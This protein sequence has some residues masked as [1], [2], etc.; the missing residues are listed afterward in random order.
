MAGDK[1]TKKKAKNTAKQ[2]FVS[3]WPSTNP[4]SSSRAIPPKTNEKLQK[5]VSP[6]LD[7]FNYFLTEG[8]DLAVSDI[9]RVPVE[10]PNQQR[11][12]IWIENAQLGFPTT[13]NQITGEQKLLPSECRQRGVSY[14]A[15]LVVTLA[16]SFGGSQNVE[17]VQKV[18]GE[19]PIMVRS[20]HCHLNGMS[21]SELVK[22]KEE[23]NEMG[24]YF[25]CNGNERCVR[26]LQMPRRHHIMAVRRGAFANRGDLYTELAVFMKCVKRDQAA[27][28]V[29]VHYLQDGNATVRFGVKKQ[30]FMIP[31]GLVLKALY[32][33]TDREIY[34]RVLRG[35]HENTYLSARVEL[36]LREAKKFS[37]YSRDEALSYLGKHFRYAMPYV[38]ESMSNVEIGSK[39]LDD[40]LFVHIP[41]GEKG[42]TQKVELLCLMLRKLYAFAKGDVPEDNADSVMNHELL[43]PGHLYLMILKEKLQEMLQSMRANILKETS[44]R[45]KTVVMDQVFLRKMW[46]RTPNVGHAMT[47][48]LN[49]GNLRSSSGL[50]LLQVA[51]YTIVAEKLNYYR[52]FSHFRS[53][54]RGQ[55]F[56][57]MKTTAVRKLLPD[58]WGFLCPVHTP[59][60]SPCGLLNHLAVE[61]QLVSYPAYKADDYLQQEVRLSRFLASLGMI[62]TSGYADGALIV[63]YSYLPVMMNG[64]VLGGAPAEVCKRIADVLR[65]VKSAESPKERD[66]NGIVVNLEVCLILPTLGGPFPGLFLSA[67]AARMSRP[68]MQMDTKRI[69]YIGPMEQVFMDIA[70]TKADIR[71]ATTHMEIKPTNML[72][73]VASLTPFSDYNQSP[74]NMY[75]CQMAKQT[76]GTPA[77]SI[78]NRTDNK[79][80]RIQSPQIPIVQNE[81]LREYQLDEYPL[82]TNAVVAVISY[83]GFD[84]EDAMILNKA[85]YERGFGHASVY[86][87]LNVD[88][89]AGGKQ[90]SAQSKKYFS[91]I[92][93]DGSGEFCSTKLDHD[94]FPH[95]GQ[96]V[97]KGDPIAGWIDETTGEAS[98]QKHKESEPAIIE[99]INMIGGSSQASE[100]TKASIKLRFCR[101]PTIG[102]KFSSR[103]GQKGV[104]SIQ[105]PQENMPFSE[106]GM[107]PDIIINPHAFPSR[108][109]IGMLIESMAAKTG[110][111]K[112][113]YMDATPFKF[114]EKDRVIDYFG[115]QLKEHGYNYMG[116]EPLYSGISGTVMQADIYIGV[117]Y[118]Q[119][120][121]HMVSD[122]SQVRATGPT[123]SLT[124]QPVKGRKKGGGIRLGEMERDSLLA[125][126]CAFLLQDRLMNCSD[127]HIATVCT[128]CGSLLSNATQRSTVETAGQGD[129]AIAMKSKTQWYC[130]VC[131][132]G[133]GCHAVAMPYVFRYLANEKLLAS[134]NLSALAFGGGNGGGGGGDNE[135][136]APGAYG[137]HVFS[138][139]H[140]Y[141]QQCTQ[142]TVYENTA[143]AVVESSLE[144][145]NATIFAYGQTGTGKTYTME[146]FNSGSGSV[147]ERGIIPRAIEQIFCHIQANVSARC[148]FL[149]RASYL[150]IYNESISDLLKPERA[151][152]TIR[153][154]RRR[155][156][157]VE[158]LSE[159]V[160]RSPEEIYG[161][162][163]RGGAM[164]ATGSTKMNE[165]SSRS[166]AVFIII[167]EQSKT[168]YVDSK[169]ND[170]A[171]EEFMALVNAYQARHGGAN[172][173]GNAKEGGGG[174]GTNANGTV[175]LHPKLEAMV[176]Q[177]FKVGKLNL[178]DLA[179]SERVRLSGATGQRLEESKKINQSLSAL[180]NVISALTDARGRQHIPYRD[181]KLT[182]I[183][184]DSLGG[185]C[186]TTMMAMVSPALEAMTES[187]STLKFANRAKHIKN[188]AKVNEDLDQKSL[189]RKYERELKRLRAELEERSRN[190]VDKRRLLELDEQRRRAEEDKMAAIRALEERSR[191][192]MREKEEKKR[193]EQRI[194]ALTS[195]MLMSNQRRLTSSSGVVS[196]DGDGEA[197][198]AEDPLIRDAIKE[199]QDRI[200]QEYECRLADLEKERETIE[201]EKAQVDRYK[202][203]LLK[204]RDIMI[205][206]TQRL[207]E[208]D[209]Q[210]TALQDELDAYDRHQ[211]ELEEKLDEKTAHLIHLQRVAMEHNA[212][213]PGKIDAELQ[214][215]LGDWG[216]VDPVII[217]DNNYS[218]GNNNLVHGGSVGSNLLSAEEKIQEMRALVD[219]QSVEHQRMAKELEEVKSEKVS[220]EFVLREKLDKL[221]QVE[222]DARVKDLNRT[223]SSQSTK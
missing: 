89:S 118:Y 74:R 175:A 19:L 65:K 146:G 48:F 79:M 26:L 62:P 121:R 28:T 12:D 5:L 166:H 221:A 44:N 201:E 138:F 214:K 128:N 49:T 69:E 148:R 174:N 116:S 124:R 169:G 108:M 45:K 111:L 152:L 126:G 216:D 4:S 7:S 112:G 43:L 154:D 207:N 61:C 15:P 73:L 209:E 202:Q 107:S 110:A 147:E 87:Q 103:H 35:D 18:V 222:L 183:L 1:S 176:R 9:A 63:P 21:P 105:W 31:V 29:T 17:R 199:H 78:V 94:G 109:T 177:S 173:P 130:T 84:M 179:G 144:G 23:A 55:F 142:S 141:D 191:E 150:Q 16:R 194:T 149:V 13:E 113:K 14:T 125:H 129:I 41:K 25:I 159:W 38:Y 30:E 180:G 95:I 139:D 145:Y 200:R 40:Y 33:L 8:L 2:E 80:Y 171:P 136:S 134:E 119:R 99:Q 215:A 42:R 219:A 32:P 88:I 192:F 72:S 24:G 155:G 47:Y 218:S 223:D 51:G 36:I 213:S 143:K 98:F 131:Q 203:L 20:K 153:E 186:K 67:D 104:C 83:T 132:T 60:G 100:F 204:Q 56:T 115:S 70:C 210:I 106:S 181:S 182:R 187:L 193:L 101:N 206:L 11:M 151:N 188:E 50:D 22:A 97:N 91:N 196:G 53:V 66:T 135:A 137:S 92:K 64:K 102:D 54:H 167:A 161:L 77:H 162:M 164:R 156:V 158:G 189:L 198:N 117:V 71:P 127:K 90:G 76:M 168:T 122:K 52:Y 197:F 39:L 96:V 58:S 10:L 34:E 211:K 185:N 46:D 178:V 220:V 208:R 157:F 81:R 37:L 59:D 172:A 93:T 57:E 140:V 212:T 27:V 3:E 170:V 217:N 68:V 86:K 195:Q 184:E 133:E 6:H 123:N 205:A 82:G 190:V 85:S 114:S 165:L 120:L 75:Q 163:E 160:V